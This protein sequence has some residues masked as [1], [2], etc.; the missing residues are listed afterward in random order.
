[1][2]GGTWYERYHHLRLWFHNRVR[3]GVSRHHSCTKGHSCPCGNRCRKH[4]SRDVFKLQPLKNDTQTGVPVG[5]GTGGT[6]GAIMIYLSVALMVLTG[7]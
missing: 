3:L 5:V 4:R 2:P 6:A 1:M 7:P